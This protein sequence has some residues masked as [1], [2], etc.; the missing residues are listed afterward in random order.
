MT[1]MVQQSATSIAKQTTKQRKPRIASPTR[2]LMKTRTY[3]TE[4]KRDHI[5]Y[6]E[7]CKTKKRKA[8]VDIWKRNL[9]DIRETFWTSK[10]LKQ[11]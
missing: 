4:N 6:V 1:E 8:R 10:S 3:I 7:I 11:I 2:A 5:E 9:D